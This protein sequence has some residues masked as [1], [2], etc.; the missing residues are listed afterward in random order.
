MLMRPR[1]TL[2]HFMQN[3]VKDGDAG[4]DFGVHYKDVD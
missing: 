1:I 2:C 4:T 3:A